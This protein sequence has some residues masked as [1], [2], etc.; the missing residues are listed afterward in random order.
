MR[1]SDLIGILELRKEQQGDIQ[2]YMDEA[3]AKSLTMGELCVTTADS[4]LCPR[5]LEIDIICGLLK[6]E[7]ENILLMG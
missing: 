5:T 1:I 7:E 3:E 6:N 2:V 4:V